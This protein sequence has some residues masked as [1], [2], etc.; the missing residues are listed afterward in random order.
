MKRLLSIGVSHKTA[1]VALREH[2]AMTPKQATRFAKDLIGHESI[3]EALVLSTCNRT[4]IYVATP[5]GNT[6]D[7]L[8][9]LT[10][11]LAEK[12]GVEVSVVARATYPLAGPDVVK[13]LYAVTAGLDS[14]VL[15]ESEIQGQ[16]KRALEAAL[17]AGTT[18]PLISRLFSSAL[19][20]GKRV[21]SETALGAAR[22]S[23]SS[24]AVDLAVKAVG[25]LEQRTVM[26]I[27]TGEIGSHTAQAL[28]ARGSRTTFI[29]NRQLER[30]HHL[31]ERFG[32]TVVPLSELAQQL[33][34]ADV[35][36]SATTSPHSVIDAAQL[37]AIMARRESRPLV[38]IDLALPRD[39][40]PNCR[41]IPGVSMY[42]LDDLQRIV[43]ATF[44][45]R[46]SERDAAEIVIG[47]ELER[48]EEWLQRRPAS[49]A[50]GEVREL[51]GDDDGRRQLTS[52]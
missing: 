12:T 25:A 29:A 11:V 36:F 30:A 18:G 8:T 23:L 15:G 24:I 5:D 2:L 10:T 9:D 48:F 7:R 28:A 43:D 50:G 37:S 47:Q 40:D 31:A 27:G 3:S 17:S 42:D 26:M 46:D 14:M 49:P 6:R 38:V 1:H 22:T 21:R 34:L 32:G 16:V 44:V 33:E 13:H 52:A 35:I 51:F 45:A 4:E 41:E 20:A 19:K 39:V